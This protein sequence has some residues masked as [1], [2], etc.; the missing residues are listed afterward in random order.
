MLSSITPLGL[1]SM[2][3]LG[4]LGV[5]LRS[6]L[7]AQSIGLIHVMSPSYLPAYHFISICYFLYGRW[8]LGNEVP[9]GFVMLSCSFN[10]VVIG[11]HHLVER[12]INSHSLHVFGYPLESQL[13]S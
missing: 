1:L 9:E 6:P 8:W 7:L 3:D 5:R 13:G 4:Q 10:L 12:V 11:A 2:F